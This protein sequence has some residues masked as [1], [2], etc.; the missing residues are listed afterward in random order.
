MWFVQ[1]IG[2][3]AKKKKSQLN[4]KI[5][6]YIYLYIFLFEKN[7]ITSTLNFL[8]RTP[9]IVPQ[10]TISQTKTSYIH[11]YTCSLTEGIAIENI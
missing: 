9:I 10:H 1:K 6:Q 5:E 4:P 2:K 3:K 11:V 8:L 7:S